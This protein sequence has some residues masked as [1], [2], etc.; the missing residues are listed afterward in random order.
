MA[1]WVWKQP[2]PEIPCGSGVLAAIRAGDGAP[3]C[4]FKVLPIPHLHHAVQKKPRQGGYL[5]GFHKYLTQLQSGEEAAHSGRGVGI[6]PPST[7]YDGAGTERFPMLVT[8]QGM[9]EAKHYQ[10]VLYIFSYD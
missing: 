1:G 3:T 4:P 10:G 5:P 9:N 7:C 6:V 8:Y 2:K